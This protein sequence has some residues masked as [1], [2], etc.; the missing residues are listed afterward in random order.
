MEILNTL[1]DHSRLLV[2]SY[3]RVTFK[4]ADIVAC[5]HHSA[6]GHGFPASL[7]TDD[8]AVFTA[9]SRGRGRVAPEAGYSVEGRTRV[10]R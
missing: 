4:A 3:T 10:T 6:A 5:F 8:P 7:L 2:G 9:A 1:D